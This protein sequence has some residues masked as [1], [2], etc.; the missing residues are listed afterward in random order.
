MMDPTDGSL[1]YL[2][3]RG[4]QVSEFTIDATSAGVNDRVLIVIDAN[5]NYLKKD[6]TQL[7][8]RW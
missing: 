3:E 5:K 1:T 6:A 7:E 8:E 4:N 2:G